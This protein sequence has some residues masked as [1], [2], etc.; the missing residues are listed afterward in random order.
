MVTFVQYKWLL[1]LQNK[2]SCTRETLISLRVRIVAL[3]KKE[4]KKCPMS[5]DMCHVSFDRCLVS[6]IRCHVSHITYHLS[7]TPNKSFCP[8]TL[9]NK[10][11]KTFK[12]YMYGW[13]NTDHNTRTLQL[14]HWIWKYAS[15]LL[16]IIEEWIIASD[17]NLIHM[18]TKFFHLRWDGSRKKNFFEMLWALGKNHPKRKN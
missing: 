2:K 14:I 7:L 1:E 16:F 9:I 10:S 13:H 17:F 11:N 4:I 8:R 5:C 3:I 18:Q 12:K 15:F 6:G